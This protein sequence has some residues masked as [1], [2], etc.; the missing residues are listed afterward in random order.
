MNYHTN[1]VTNKLFYPNNVVHASQNNHEEKSLSLLSQKRLYSNIV[2]P[3]NVKVTESS[4]FK[5]P[6]TLKELQLF[7]YTKNYKPIVSGINHTISEYNPVVNLVYENSNDETASN[8]NLVI[9]IKEMSCKDEFGMFHQFTRGNIPMCM[10]SKTSNGLSV[11]NE[12]QISDSKDFLL[13]FK[14]D[15]RKF[16]LLDT[17]ISRLY[18]KIYYIAFYASEDKLKTIERIISKIKIILSNMDNMNLVIKSNILHEF[19][20]LFS[21][22]GL[23]STNTPINDRISISDDV[24]LD[25]IH[26]INI[27]GYIYLNKNNTLQINNAQQFLE[28]LKWFQQ[29]FDVSDQEVYHILNNMRKMSEVVEEKAI[30][31]AIANV[32]NTMQLTTKLLKYKIINADDKVN[33]LLESLYLMERKADYLKQKAD[34]L[35][36]LNS[37]LCKI[38]NVNRDHKQESKRYINREL[39]WLVNFFIVLDKKE[40]NMY[41]FDKSEINILKCNIHLALKELNER[42]A[43]KVAPDNFKT[44]KVNL[45]TLQTLLEQYGDLLKNSISSKHIITMI[46]KVSVKCE[47]LTSE[48]NTLHDQMLNTDYKLGALILELNTGVMQLV[49]AIRAVHKKDSSSTFNINS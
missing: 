36:K 18:N 16:G 35:Q 7:K 11:E 4:E 10:F 30:T 20:Q 22:F 37:I 19:N 34:D 28:R 43:I 1:K 27:C 21:S 40:I 48:I 38:A 12:L 14:S 8:V 24:L 5:V 44:L 46:K 32:N 3:K 2:K 25:I 45:I 42:L 23:S 49:K 41:S 17:T 15:L 13:N 6:Y 9:N 26:G 31:D 29:N 47:K 39:Q 33:G